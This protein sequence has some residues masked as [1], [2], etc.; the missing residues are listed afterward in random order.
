MGF[1]TDLLKDLPVND[2]LQDELE[3]MEEDYEALEKENAALRQKNE[4]LKDK[5]FGKHNLRDSLIFLALVFWIYSFVSFVCALIVG[6]HIEF[7]KI[8]LLWYIIIGNC[9]SIYHSSIYEFTKPKIKIISPTIILILVL[10]GGFIFHLYIYD[11]KPDEQIDY[12]ASLFFIL[13]VFVLSLIAYA[14]LLINVFLE[15]IKRKS[16][17]KQNN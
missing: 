11:T 16:I 1:I 10:L 14:F 2:V 15:C 17:E 8:F 6:D 13:I 12:F 3:Q 5:L 9:F 4:Q 7:S